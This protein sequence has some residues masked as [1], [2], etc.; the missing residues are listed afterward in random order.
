MSKPENNHQ[1]A[2]KPSNQP[3]AKKEANITFQALI[4]KLKDIPIEKVIRELGVNLSNF[5]K[6]GA[7]LTG[8][9]PTGHPSLSGSSFHITPSLNLY[10]CWNC[11]IGGDNIKLVEDL[12]GF[13]FLES[14]SWLINTFN[15]GY[16][17][18][19][20]SIKKRTPEEIQKDLELRTK[21][22]LYEELIQWGKSLMYDQTTTDQGARDAYNYLTQQRKYD[23]K[24]LESTNFFYVP[25]EQQAKDHLLKVF[26]EYVVDIRNLR[27]AGGGF[28]DQMTINIPYYDARGNISGLIKRYHT[29][30]GF[31]NGRLPNGNVKYA[32]WDSTPGLSKKDMFGL[33]GLKKMNKNIKDAVVVEGYPDS[34]YMQALGIPVLSLG[35]GLPADSQLD[36]LL[37]LK[38]LQSITISLDNDKAGIDNTNTVLINLSKRSH[39]VIQ[40]LPHDNLK[41]YKDLDEYFRS[42]GS[43]ETKKLIAIAPILGVEWFI[44]HE[45]EKNYGK[46]A[47][48]S[49]SGIYDLISSSPK[50]VQSLVLGKSKQLLNMHLSTLKAII[51]EREVS[52]WAE[53]YSLDSSAN[54]LFYWKKIPFTHDGG[55]GVF[56][57]TKIPP[58]PEV[59]D[60]K[61][62]KDLREFDKVNLSKNKSHVEDLVKAYITI[63]PVLPDLNLIYDPHNFYEVDPIYKRI[64]TFVPT[65]W[66]Y[67]EKNNEIITPA[68]FPTIYGFIDHLLGSDQGVSTTHIINWIATIFNKREKI[69]T[70]LII[71]G[72]QGA[73]KG[74]FV[75]L[76]IKY[77]F[78]FPNVSIVGDKQLQDG[79]NEYLSRKLFIVF[80]ELSS[81]KESQREVQTFLKSLITDPTFQKNVKFMSLEQEV[82]WFNFIFISN[83]LS[84]VSIDIDDRRFTAIRVPSEKLEYSSFF[85]AN[86]W[87]P[88]DFDKFRAKIEEEF[89]RFV[90]YLKNYDYDEKLANTAI[91]NKTKLGMIQDN[92][93]IFVQFADLLKNRDVDELGF[94][95]SNGSTKY[96]IKSEPWE[97]SHL[98]QGVIE[99]N[100][101]L[102]MFNE[103]AQFKSPVSQHTLRNKLFEQG[104]EKRQLRLSCSWKGK[105][106]I[107][108]DGKVARSYFYVLPGSEHSTKKQLVS[109]ALRSSINEEQLYLTERMIKTYEAKISDLMKTPIAEREDDYDQI[110]KVSTEHIT[111][112]QKDLAELKRVSEQNS[113]NNNNN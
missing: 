16:D 50:A 86:G 87:K 102:S 58:A 90:Q 67:Y 45:R 25:S 3:Q 104:I 61:E 1:P 93:T 85:K 75:D 68:E 60:A 79:F 66:M 110:L 4:N 62:L 108:T 10:H 98:K 71:V 38:Q 9:C 40:V 105:E 81:V 43:E 35:A 2:N 19:E 36:S 65:K 21:T 96:S 11:G 97:E 30:Q 32:R 54:P 83:F 112:L 13:T 92:N 26:P 101:A 64:N 27:I 69:R 20:F 70:S 76:I 51:A 57:R 42:K 49:L 99:V 8:Q 34:V 55:Y 28:H 82:A 109:V 77:L 80:N 15:L 84:P 44:Q 106:D 100:Q 89:P 29:G 91:M 48:S 59:L 22:L 56:D 14:L 53:L 94:L 46:L 24:I 6:T 41:P 74:I 103:I 73:G 78:G 37:N 63:P 39:L 23:P 113:N 33:Y 72:H 52:R 47:P 18:T 88:E 107:D 7:N 31:P 5:N 12:K 95:Q 111:Q 17:L